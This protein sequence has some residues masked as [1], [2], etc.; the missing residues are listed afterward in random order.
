M[1]ES[2]SVPTGRSCGSGGVTL[3]KMFIV[4]FWDVNQCQFDLLP[5]IQCSCFRS[6]IFLSFHFLLRPTTKPTQVK[7]RLQ[8]LKT[9]LKCT[10]TQKT[11]LL[12]YSNV[13]KCN[14][15]IS[16][17]VFT[18]IFFIGLSFFYRSLIGARSSQVGS[19]IPVYP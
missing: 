2:H 16:T 8:I 17:S 11:I 15:Y 9:S 1:N 3:V 19:R 4:V 12:S 13:S 10:S 7:V 14:S 6:V 18:Y 5:I